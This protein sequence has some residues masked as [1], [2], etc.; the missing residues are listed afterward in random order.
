MNAEAVRDIRAQITP[1]MAGL[2]RQI[3]GN[4]NPGAKDLLG[5]LLSTDEEARE[6]VNKDVRFYQLYSLAIPGW[7]EAG[8]NCK[9]D[10][11]IVPYLLAEALDRGG[12]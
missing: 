5:W 11:D 9:N 2:L 10:A 7:L 4:G 6:F 12:Q 8:W 1:E 3:Q